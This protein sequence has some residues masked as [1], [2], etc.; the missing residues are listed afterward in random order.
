MS[1]REEP[2]HT[3]HAEELRAA[4]RLLTGARQVALFGHVNPDADAF[5]SAIG[6]GLALRDAGADVL[7]SFGEPDEVPESLRHLDPA[8]LYVPASKV[9][10]APE[11]IVCLD[12]SVI[13]RLGPLADRVSATLAAGGQVLIIDHHVGGVP[14]GT[15]Q[16]IDST[17]EATAAI[18]LRLLDEM[19][20]PLTEPIAAAL[21][22]GLLTDTGSFRRARV[23]THES[24]A[25][26][27]AAGV[28]A[29]SVARPLLDTHPFAW[30]A[31][32]STVLGR[33]ELEP[34]AAHGLGWVHTVVHSADMAGVRVEEIES[35]IGLLAGTAEAEVAVVL[36]QIGPSRW[37]GSLRAVSRVDVSAVARTLGGGGHRLAA[38]FTANGTADEVLATLRTELAQAPLLT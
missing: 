10:P 38:G 24:A 9:P 5:G 16:V 28:N 19:H 7:V 21:Y 36:K 25:R 8:G 37:S 13:G 15:H 29:Q 20:A 30:L 12:H 1:V 34:D 18:V 31:M 4:A 11:L 22:A 26:L 2:A 32:L 23:S 3:D 35:V 17:A 33:A 14:F 27:L 6:L